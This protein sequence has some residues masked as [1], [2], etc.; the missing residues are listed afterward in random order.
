MKKTCVILAGIVTAIISGCA[1][2]PTVVQVAVG[3]DPFI[4]TQPSP[5]GT[6]QVF[7][8]TAE[9]NNVGTEF[10]YYERTSYDIYDSSGNLIKHVRDNNKG[11]FVASPRREYLTPGIYRIKALAA[12]GTGEWMMVSVVVEPGRTTEVHLNGHWAPPSDTPGS[13]LVYA[14]AGFPLGWRASIPPNS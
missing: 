11:E 13:A 10:P 14:P 12:I 5:K 6:L 9:E 3:P 1:S 2:Q 8:A 4:A 7:T